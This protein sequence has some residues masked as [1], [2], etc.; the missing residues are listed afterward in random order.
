MDACEGVRAVLIVTSRKVL[1]SHDQS[2]IIP[3]SLNLL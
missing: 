1:A 2:V 3:L